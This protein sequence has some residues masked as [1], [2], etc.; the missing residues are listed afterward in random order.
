MART[1][2]ALWQRAARYLESNQS[3]PARVMLESIFA[4][5]ATDFRAC[6]ALA[7]LEWRSGKVRDAAKWALSAS[8]VAADAPSAIIATVHALLQ[9]G[10]TAAAHA[11][12]ARVTAS[13]AKLDSADLLRLASECQALG[14]H[15]DARALLER[16]R[17]KGIPD[18]PFRFM[19]AMELGFAGHLDTASSELESCIAAGTRYGRVYV[20]AAR[21]R[22]A[23]AADNHLQII[24][25]K[26]AKAAP[27]GEDAAALEFAR[28]KEFED[29]G[30][31]DDAWAALSRGNAIMASS[32]R[33]DP[34]REAALLDRLLDLCTESFLRHAPSGAKTGPRPIFII[35]MTRSGTTLLD[36]L[37]GAHPD[38]LSAGELHDFGQQLR[39]VADHPG[40]LAPDETMLMRLP[41]LDFQELGRRYL[42][43]TRWRANG[44]P[45]FTDKRPG[46]WVVAGLIAKA[47]P[48]A[49]ILNMVRD[50]IDVC[51]SNFRAFFSH[52]YPWSYELRTLASQYRQYAKGMR[53]WHAVLPGR[54]LDV[55]YRKLVSE[56][57]ATL[58]VV[59]S[60]CGLPWNPACLDARR[61]EAPAATLSF[62]QVRRPLHRRSFEA[63]QPYARQLAP[64][65][66]ALADP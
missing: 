16:A 5:D 66:Q 10:E 30:R 38:V 50:P 41:T 28:Y 33:H 20:E 4:Q 49:C 7:G 47:L 23:T 43:Q 6:L 24:E 46:N 61:N 64:L 40:R 17:E 31:F 62:E 57:E 48:E 12:V 1:I 56:P 65:R 27:D 39:W 58:R 55:P 22:R 26:L 54:I 42:T 8:E 45:Y 18:I 44:R 21:L 19:H 37:L 11:T 53:H 34:G 2:E 13:P 63:W 15:A 25:D 32:M 35:G 36:R 14:Q 9:V 29:L 51:F 52:A 59:L 3:A 60:H